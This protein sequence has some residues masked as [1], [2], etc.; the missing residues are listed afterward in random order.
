MTML[1]RLSQRVFNTPL[2]IRPEKAEIIV[3]ALAER[4]GVSKLDRVD[5]TTLGV[6]EMRA[7]A[8]DAE[9][10]GPNRKIYAEAEGVAVIPVLDTLVQ[11]SDY[12]DPE[13]GV[14]GYNWIAQ[15]LRAAMGDEAIKAIWL[16]IDSPGGE[17]NG[18]FALAEEIAMSTKS[19]GGK[20]IWA[21]VNEQACSGAYALASVCDKIFMPEDGIAASIGAYVMHVD[22]SAALTKEGIKATIIRSGDRKGRMTE[23]EPLDDPAVAK[24][25]AWVDRTR[26]RF[27]RLVADGRRLA[28][29][30]VMDTEADWFGAQECV[31]LGLAD[32]IMSEM[33]AWAKLQRSL[34][35]AA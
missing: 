18:C 26:E 23:V 2:L 13:S 25:Q 33:E 3:C 20:P 27:A 17:A 1:G 14:T 31:D 21:Y 16:D 4:L 11:R 5:G 24:L 22:L 8:S 32:G 6:L 7:A 35:R 30:K 15:K 28:V 10:S 12:V 29:K 34:A 9:R 19:E